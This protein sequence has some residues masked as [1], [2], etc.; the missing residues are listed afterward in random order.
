[1]LLRIV[2]KYWKEIA[3]GMAIGLVVIPLVL[4]LLAGFNSL[5]G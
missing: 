1:M 5:Y 2:S 4:F 3:I